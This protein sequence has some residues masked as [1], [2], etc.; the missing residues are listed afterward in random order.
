M[1]M[2]TGAAG[3]IGSHII[4]GLNARGYTDIIAIDD[5]SHGKKF[6]NLA[7][8]QYADYLDYEDFLQSIMKNDSFG[9]T[10]DGIFHQGACA[11]TTEW[12][13]RYM[14]QN[15]YEYSK[16]LLHYCL[17]HNVPLVYAS[18]AAVYG[19]SLEKKRVSI[20][21][22][23]VYAYSKSL[24]DH[25]CTP[26]MKEPNSLVT[27]LRYFNVYGPREQ[28]KGSM[29]SMPYQAMMQL[30][31][32]GTIQLFGEYN[33]YPPGEQTRDFVWV[34]DVAQVNLWCLDHVGQCGGIFDVG[35][36]QANSFNTL[37]SILIRLHG[38]GDIQY[39]PF[40][41]RLKSAYQSY[42]CADLSPLRQRG[43]DEPFQSLD[44]GLTQYFHEHMPLL[45]G[46]CE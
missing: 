10:I 12:N 45:L 22:L 5:L 41:A 24:F 43:Y 27:G 29:A 44:A 9:S 18:S 38:S 26:Y 19:R 32:E 11:D 17:R 39:I 46:E 4:S 6:Y 13:G 1:M 34:G 40:P 21:P 3:L 30:K 31:R 42:T 14:M 37:A 15:N 7:V 28:H 16:Q 20:E 25:Y 33:G 8:N 36:G 35:T 23:N 2:V